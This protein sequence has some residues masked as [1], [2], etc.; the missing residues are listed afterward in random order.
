MA[1]RGAAKGRLA[2]KPN[3]KE[4]NAKKRTKAF[5]PGIAASGSKRRCAARQP[6]ST[7]AK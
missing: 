2:P 7:S 1:L 4:G 5:R 6:T 3:R